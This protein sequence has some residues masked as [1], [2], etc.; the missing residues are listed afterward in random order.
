V[1]NVLLPSTKVKVA[2]WPEG[3]RAPSASRLQNDFLIKKMN[4]KYIYELGGCKNYTM[5]R[6]ILGRR[7]LGTRILGTRILVGSMGDILGS[8]LGRS[9]GLKVSM[10]KKAK[11]QTTTKKKKKKK[12]KHVLSASSKLVKPSG[13]FSLLNSTGV[14]HDLNYY[15]ANYY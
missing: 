11:F 9:I 15:N 1:A 14:I 8:I 3:R 12:K 6:R 2:A 7:I 4:N 13:K 10:K 5:G